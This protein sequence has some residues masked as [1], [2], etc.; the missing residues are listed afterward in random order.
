MKELQR[1]ER[2]WNWSYNNTSD[3][4]VD[5]T[6]RNYPAFRS[7][8]FFQLPVN[9][10][11]SETRIGTVLTLPLPK[12]SC[13]T[14]KPTN[15]LVTGLSAHRATL[16]VPVKMVKIQA[17]VPCHGTRRIVGLIS[18]EILPET[19]AFS[20]L[21]WRKLTVDNLSALEISQSWISEL[22]RAWLWE[23]SKT[24]EDEWLSCWDCGDELWTVTDEFLRKNVGSHAFSSS[25][26]WNGSTSCNYDWFT[27]KAARVVLNL[28]SSIWTEQNTILH[29]ATKW[30][31]V[32]L[33]PFSCFFAM[34]NVCFGSTCLNGRECN[35]VMWFKVNE[36]HKPKIDKQLIARLTG[37]Q[38]IFIKFGKLKLQVFGTH[39]RDRQV[40]PWSLWQ[41]V[42]YWVHI[43]LLHSILQNGQA[44]QPTYFI[45]TNLL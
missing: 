9:L 28:E 43:D 8:F 45:K 21:H 11:H 25:L 35:V 2:V 40:N 17:A 19:T 13:L 14:A 34:G 7:K 33:F 4:E 38:C 5:L 20:S 3:A 44:R 27:F 26:L 29:A 31:G 41:L 42:V 36:L 23:E 15:Q 1:A 30:N 10:L 24:V 32:S 39:A 22:K 37:S 12:Q 18:C 6:F 16:A